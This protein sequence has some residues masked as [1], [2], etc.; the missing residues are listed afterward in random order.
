MPFWWRRRKRFWKRRNPYFKRKNYRKRKPIRRR[1]RTKRIHR[2]RRRRRRYKVR[3]KKQKIPIYQWQ[4]DSIRKC[5]I[6]GVG[7]LVLGAHGKQFVCYT[8][9]QQK[10]PPPRSPGGGGFACQ[11]FSL[12]LLY[13]QYK[14]RNNIWTHTNINYDLVRY[15]RTVFTFYRHSDIDFI[16]TYDRQPPFILDKLTYPLCHPQTYC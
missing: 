4:P 1:R 14:F 7:V 2:R 15:I 12:Q 8:D 16:I 10:A 9:V 6:K 13:E 11:Q 3:R 5:K